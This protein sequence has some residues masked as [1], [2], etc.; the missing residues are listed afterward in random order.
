[1][2]K[3]KTWFIIYKHYIIIYE[4]VHEYSLDARYDKRFNTVEKFFDNILDV[5]KERYQIAEYKITEKEYAEII[6]E[7]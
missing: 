6:E 3:C 7:A 2:T 5:L 1:M 4:E